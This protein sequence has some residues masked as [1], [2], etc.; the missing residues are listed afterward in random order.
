MKKIKEKHV[1]V[2]QEDAGVSSILPGCLAV[3]VYCIL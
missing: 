3:L 2:Q 1:A